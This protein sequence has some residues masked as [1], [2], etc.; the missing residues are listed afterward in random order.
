MWAGYFTPAHL[1]GTAVR[2]F[3]DLGLH[4]EALRHADAAILLDQANARTRIL[5]T[6]LLATT[7]ADAGEV[8]HAAD[9]GRQALLL[10]GPVRSRRVRRRFD[11]LTHRLAPHHRVGCVP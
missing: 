6:A 9:L 4:H 11:E 5:H 10:V 8:D 2:C 1:A 7:Y 3:R